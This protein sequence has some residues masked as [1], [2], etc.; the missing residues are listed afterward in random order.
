MSQWINK[1]ILV[2][3]TPDTDIIIPRFGEELTA[4]IIGRP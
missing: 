3:V 4:G 2:A 1:R